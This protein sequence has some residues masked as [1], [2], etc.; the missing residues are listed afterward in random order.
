MH[1]CVSWLPRV[2][3]RLAVEF[4]LAHVS[5]VALVMSELE[6]SH[7]YSFPAKW[8]TKAGVRAPKIGSNQLTD[9]GIEAED[10]CVRCSYRRAGSTIV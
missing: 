4:A 3:L 2:S 1:V 7:K 8:S 10:R 5:I 6:A 9:W